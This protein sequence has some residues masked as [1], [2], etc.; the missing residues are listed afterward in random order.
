MNKKYLILKSNPI[1]ME[2]GGFLTNFF[3]AKKSPLWGSGNS[4]AGWVRQSTKNNI[5]ENQVAPNGEAIQPGQIATDDQMANADQEISDKSAKIAGGVGM[6]LQAAG[7]AAGFMFNN[8]QDKAK[9]SETDGFGNKVYDQGNAKL[10]IAKGATMGAVKGAQMGMTFGPWGAAVGGALGAAVGLIG[11]KKKAKTALTAYNDGLNNSIMGRNRDNDLLNSQMLR[12][13]KQGLKLGRFTL[14]KEKSNVLVLRSGGKI[15][16]PGAV[17]VVVKGKLHREN[18]NLGNKD[19]GIPVV[20]SNGVKE[21][22]VEAGELI[23]RQEITQ[24]IEEYSKKYDETQDENLF[25]ELGKILVK[26]LLKNTQDNHGTFGVKVKE[27]AN[28]DRK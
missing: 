25:E 12:T 6:G 17:N 18:N 22:E 19:K 21:Y 8:A 13:G 4:N 11:G 28:T 2:T 3:G 20:D 23:F 9:N 26:E 1:S 5:L 24:L 27:D 16:E 15:E 14:P 10:D 7:M